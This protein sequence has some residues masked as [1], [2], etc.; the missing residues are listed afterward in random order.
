[1]AQLSKNL[2]NSNII[3]LTLDELLTI[4]TDQIERYGG[5][6]GIRDLGLIESALFRPQSTFSG[7]DLYPNILEKATVLVHSLL[8]N[9]AFVDGN[10]RTAIAS[11]LVFLE[12]NGISVK[13]TSDELV[14]FALSVENKKLDKEKITSWLEEHTAKTSSS[15]K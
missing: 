10:K 2:P 15:I 7:E 8:L 14:D 1:M 5:S 13:C 6:H 11:L 4:H 3:Y 9:H 12:L